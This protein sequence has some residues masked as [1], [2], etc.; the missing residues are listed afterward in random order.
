MHSESTLKMLKN[1][2]GLAMWLFEKLAL[3]SYNFFFLLHVMSS[4]GFNY[5]FSTILTSGTL[6]DSKLR[7]FTLN[8][9]V[10]PKINYAL[11]S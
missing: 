7:N 6:Y 9:T 10:I 4:F 11:V 5:Q 2:S 3:S 8:Y 1:R